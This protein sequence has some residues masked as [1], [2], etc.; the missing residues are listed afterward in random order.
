M[1]MNAKEKAR[2]LGLLFGVYTAVSLGIVLVVGIIYT[3]ILAVVA[4]AEPARGSSPP[5]DFLLP[6]VVVVFAIAFVVTFLFAIPEI[7]AAYALRKEKP[8]ARIWTIVASAIACMSFPLGTALGVFGL[9]F[10]FSEEGRAYF[11]E[12]DVRG[13]RLNAQASLTPPQPPNS[14]Q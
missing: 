11:E 3:V 6:F 9:V 8:Y 10:T 5:P 2:L 12:L 1:A 4:S 14:W 13:R 7:V